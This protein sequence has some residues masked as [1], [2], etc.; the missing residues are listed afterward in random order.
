MN[1]ATPVSSPHGWHGIATGRIMLEVILACVPGLAVLIWF[2]GWGPLIN[3]VW[4]CCVGVLLEA[5][6][7]RLRGR[8]VRFYLSDGSA[9]VTAV[10]LGLSLP[11]TLPW[12]MSLIGIA[13][14]IL[15]A[16][17]LYGGLGYNLFNPAM[18]GY[19]V[20]LIS[21][22]VE[23]T[24]W[25]VPRGVLEQSPAV[26]G[27]LDS[28]QAIFTMGQ[29]SQAI[30]AFTG[31][32]AL[33]EFKL[34][35]GGMTAGEFMAGN[36]LFGTW[37]G[38][39]WEWVNLAFLA[40]GLWLLYR[41][42]ISWHIPAA[43]LLSQ[44]LLSALFYDGGSSAGHGSP[45]LHLFG[46]ATMLGAFFI[47]TDPVTAATTPRGKIIFGALI[48]LLVYV[49]RTWGGYPDAVA[50]AVLLGNFTTPLIDYYTK[51]RAFGR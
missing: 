16:K 33:D 38:R 7:I 50:F 9:L 35:R 6:A 10:L 34:Q 15:I 32:T 48:G 23:M 45:L 22:P 36:P 28:L 17:H 31:A 19:V 43:M 13:F 21:F 39:G 49:I 51:P 5:F 47:A 18:V 29:S 2:F 14:A 24:T 26:P 37:S 3:V 40:G 30:D 4:L 25:L 8:S 44:T 12:W 11:P 1:G 20:L 27:F 42:I 46:G 41:K